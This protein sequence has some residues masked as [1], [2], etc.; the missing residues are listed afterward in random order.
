MSAS[1]GAEAQP[2]L[3]RREPFDDGHRHLPAPEAHDVLAAALGRSGADQSAT[4][5]VR[6][7]LS[8]SHDVGVLEPY[9]PMPSTEWTPSPGR[10]HGGEIE[11]LQRKIGGES[12]DAGPETERLKALLDAEPP[13]PIGLRHTPK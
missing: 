8:H 3:C 1:P 7:L 4:E 9:L 11:L 6:S 13:A 12:H 10:D 5:A 2:G